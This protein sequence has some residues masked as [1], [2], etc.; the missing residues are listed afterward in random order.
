MSCDS[1][2]YESQEYWV[3]LVSDSQQVL[4][5]AVMGLGRAAVQETYGMSWLSGRRRLESMGVHVR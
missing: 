3:V 5:G 2:A 4:T 1:F